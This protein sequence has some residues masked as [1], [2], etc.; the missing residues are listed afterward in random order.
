LEARV[1]VDVEYNQRSIHDGLVVVEDQLGWPGKRAQFVFDME[2]VAWLNYIYI[3]IYFVG[4]LSYRVLYGV[5]CILTFLY[6]SKEQGTYGI[7]ET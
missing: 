5:G 1:V 6:F 3:Y 7:T 2:K 4:S